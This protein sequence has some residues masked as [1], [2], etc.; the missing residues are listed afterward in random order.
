MQVILAAGTLGLAAG[1]AGLCLRSHFERTHLSTDTYRL[2][3]D[4]LR[5]GTAYRV[6]FLTDL[7]SNVFGRDN[8]PLL[9]AVRQAKPDLVLIGGDMMVCRQQNHSIEVALKLVRELAGEYPV[10]YG[11]GN[12]E[13]RMYRKRQYYGSL[14][15]ELLEG[16]KKCGVTHLQDAW[17][18]PLPGLRVYGVDI[19]RPY[20]EK[21]HVPEMPADYL[22][23]RF[24]EPDRDRFNVLLAHTPMFFDVY[25]GWGADL[26]LSG[27]FHGGTIRLPFIGGLMTP[28]YQFFCPYCAGEFTKGSSK[29]IV[30][31]G[32]GT[33]SINIRLGNM[34]QLVVAEICGTAD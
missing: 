15:E 13:T 4:K 3:T 33:H 9:S 10:C 21:G 24:G 2:E 7:H 1:A 5:K 14:Y 16:L 27:H 20:Y 19:E 8:E 18:D 26:T 34:S 31:R 32:L 28:Q 22:A 17:A 11:N 23:K 25:A 30:G 12:H 29:M 6:V